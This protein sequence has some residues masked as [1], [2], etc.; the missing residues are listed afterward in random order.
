VL[1]RWGREHSHVG[2]AHCCDSVELDRVYAGR[3]VSTNLASVYAAKSFPVVE[4]HVVDGTAAVD[5][6]FAVSNVRG[7][8]PH[9]PL[10]FLVSS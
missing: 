9:R 7:M 5:D 4:Q 10:T 8:L 1:T 2:A 3:V 6:G